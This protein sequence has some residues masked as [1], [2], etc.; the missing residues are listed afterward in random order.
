MLTFAVLSKSTT[1]PFLIP[2]GKKYIH[3]TPKHT[4]VLST[5]NK[6]NTLHEKHWCVDNPCCDINTFF[7]RYRIHLVDGLNVD[8]QLQKTQTCYVLCDCPKIKSSTNH[9]SY[10]LLE[11]KKGVIGFINKDHALVLKERLNLQYHVVEIQMPTLLKYAQSIHTSVIVLY[12]SY[13]DIDTRF[14]YFLYFT[15][16]S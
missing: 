9:L 12:N 1:L 8:T 3:S 6:N 4:R 7:A 5:N 2:H 15:L 14:S 16:V 11:S 13:T 10:S